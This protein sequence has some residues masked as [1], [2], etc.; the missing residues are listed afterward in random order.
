M[1]ARRPVFFN[2][3]QIQMPVGSITSI[4]HRVSG[5]L[6]A[7]GIPYSIYLLQ[8]AIEGPQTYAHVAG[9]LES[10]AVRIALAL[11]VWAL[12]HHVLAGLRHMFSDIDI[13]S[14]L[15]AARRSAWIVNGAGLA[16]GLLGVA[17]LF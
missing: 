17:A 16:I 11:W 13:G 9:M 1:K 10:T 7:L 15:P 5:V 3:V 4:M 2:L 6:L 8:L 12:A 14:R